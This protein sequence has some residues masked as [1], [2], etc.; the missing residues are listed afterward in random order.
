VAVALGAGH[1]LA[2]LGD[3]TVFAWGSSVYGQ[4]DVPPDLSDVIAVAAGYYHSL[5]LRRDGTVVA[6]GEDFF[7]QSSVPAGLADVV[8]IAG[9]ATHSVAL[10]RDGTIVTWGRI[11]TQVSGQDPQVI[12]VFV[13]AGLINVQAI[14]AGD[15][16][17]VALAGQ[18]DEPPLLRLVGPNREQTRFRA[19]LETQRGVFYFLESTESLGSS[20]WNIMPPFPGDGHGVELTDPF[21]LAPARFY[22]VR[23]AR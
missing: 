18:A 3:G 2:L 14:T 23:T 8:A 6:W 5:A 20:S 17:T 21:A 4:A 12:P 16:F 22:R 1:S 7:G 10:K 19:S 11:T 15:S 9:G 13:L